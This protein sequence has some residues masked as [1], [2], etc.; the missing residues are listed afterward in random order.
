[1][2]S[3]REFHSTMD[4]YDL[5]IVGGGLVGGSLACALGGA[6]LRVCVVEAVAPTAEHQ[7]SYDERVIALSWGSRLILEGVGLW[8]GIAAGAE[9]IRRIH[10]SD[11]GHFG[12]SRLDCRDE[13]VD[14]LGYVAPARLLGS[15]IQAKLGAVELLCPAH[16]VELGLQPGWVDLEV[17]CSGAP[18]RIRS[19]LLVA[20]DGGD[21]SIRKRLGFSVRERSYD[22]DALI[23]T[24]TPDRPQSGVAFERFTD[25]GPLA[26]LPLTEG[27]YSVVWTARESE[28]PGLLAL[29]DSAFLE[30]LQARFGYRLGRFSHPG[31]RVAYPLKL[32]LTRDPVRPRLVLIG[33]AAH[34]LHPVAGQGYNLGLRDV[35]ALAQVVSDSIREGG[36]PGE[37]RT[38]EAYRRL[39]GADQA[40]VA[41]LTDGLARLFVNDWL[42]LRLGRDLG[43]V[44]LDLIP[45]VRHLLTRRFMGIGGRSPLLGRGLPLA[46]F[47]RPGARATADPTGRG[48][49]SPNPRAGPRPAG[50][51]DAERGPRS[52]SAT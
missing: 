44:G 15:A 5:V 22:H 30:R 19:R 2:V 35:A 36:D 25:S 9:P 43:M 6:G 11:R 52:E 12:F 26:L 10:I 27:R 17:S 33:N 7:P 14:A 48:H 51:G 39:R 34:T 3:L 46:P 41:T 20:A 4:R 21:S 45:G 38:L 49:P 29:D 28:T 31:R 37:D 16:L 8:S 42:P 50:G 23:T 18:R 1:V 32:L 24:V 47:G 40:R 13:A